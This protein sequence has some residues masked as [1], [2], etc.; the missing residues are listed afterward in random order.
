VRISAVVEHVFYATVV[1]ADGSEVDA[2]PSD[3]LALALVAGAPITAEP[4]VLESAAHF[5]GARRPEFAAEVAGPHDGASVLA[6]ET[7]EL[8]AQRTRKLAEL[9]E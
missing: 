3:A 7:R 5:L 6:D 8:L 2:R 4:A 9:D 1:L